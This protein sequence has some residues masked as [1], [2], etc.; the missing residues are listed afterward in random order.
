VRRVP[1]A[2]A[3]V[4]VALVTTL[5]PVSPAVAAPLSG[6]TI[7]I[8][9]GHN[10][11]DGAHPTA[12]NKL[13]PAGGFLKACDTTGTAI[14]GGISEAAFN[15]DVARR[16]R[17]VLAGLG[18]RVVM[19]RTTNDGVGPCVNERAAI[20]NRAHA[21]AAIS[22][23]A[24][25]NLSRGNR[26][27]HVIEPGYLRGYTGPIVAPSHRLALAVR[28]AMVRG[29]SMPLSNYIGTRGISTR[30]DLGGLNLSRVPKVFVES[31]N[32]DD[33]ADA[34]LLS[35]GRFRAREALALAAGLRAFL[36]R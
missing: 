33:R 15:L 32:M 16:L 10:G 3:G 20:G 27:F 14:P 5:A 36:G 35:S 17:R 22:I 23:H 9:P 6:V 1:R 30:T 7:A 31:G 12:I 28:R 8:D 34:A 18:A 26:G 11:A 25:G 19:T 21:S 29:T 2:L 24:D 13:V 4:V